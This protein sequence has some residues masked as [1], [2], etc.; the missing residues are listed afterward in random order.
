VGQNSRTNDTV[1]ARPERV[2]ASA[3]E[4]APDG[5]KT[6]VPFEPYKGFAIFVFL[7]D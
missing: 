2:A 4:F 5:L 7:K 6:F 1:S 3:T